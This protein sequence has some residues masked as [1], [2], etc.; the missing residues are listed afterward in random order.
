MRSL[1]YDELFIGGRWQAPSTGQ[2]ALGDL[3]HTEQPIGET[4]EATAEDVDKAVTAARKAFD[5]GPWPRL[6]VSRAD[7]EDREARR[8]LHGPHRRDGRPHHRG[9]GLAPQLQPVGAGN[10]GPVARCT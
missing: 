10:R 8:R 6:A 5:D 9:D 3:P 7:G 4:P 1:D 2:T